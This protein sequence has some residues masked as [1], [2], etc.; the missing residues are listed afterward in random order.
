MSTDN[1]VTQGLFKPRSIA[2][3]DSNV[4][5]ADQLL[6]TLQTDQVFLL[7]GQS[8]GIGQIAQVLTQYT[9]LESVHIFSH[10][11]ENTL[12]F[13]NGYL[14]QENIG[15]YQ[16]ALTDWGNALSQDGDLLFYG[17]NIAAGG[18]QFIQQVS[19]VTQADVAASNNLTG[20]QLAIQPINK[21]ILQRLQQQPLYYIIYSQFHN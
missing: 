16:E 12:Q 13:A 17:C 4:A 11:N 5:Q 10:G 8:H 21:H 7:D 20:Q 15:N 2:F 6:Q 14:S 3:V 19:Q 1:I 18:D 9:N